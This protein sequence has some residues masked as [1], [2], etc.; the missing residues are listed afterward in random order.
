M[1]RIF[2]N[3]VNKDLAI[4]TG[5]FYKT[6]YV[7]REEI[8]IVT[9]LPKQLRFLIGNNEFDDS[10]AKPLQTAKDIFVFGCTVALRILDLF[11][12]KFRDVEYLGDNYYLPVNTIKTN[13]SIRIKL[14]KYA[15]EI[16]EKFKRNSRGRASIFP[17]I[18]ATSFNGQ[19]KKIAF[20]A[21]W[22]KE[23]GKLRSR[24]GIAIELFLDEKKIDTVFAILYL[25]IPCSELLLQLC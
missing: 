13:T 21:G 12:I 20:L 19:L 15:V 18:P 1:I 23:T 2:F 22:T 11:A 8:P 25:L 16:I 17:A 9:L 10:L 6:F 24:R 5:D 4:T 7:C 3:F 14:P